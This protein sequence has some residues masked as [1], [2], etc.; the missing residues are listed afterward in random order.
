[1]IEPDNRPRFKDLVHEF[2]LMARDPPRYVVIQV[3]VLPITHRPV[4]LISVDKPID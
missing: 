4:C 3:N 2:T 1:M